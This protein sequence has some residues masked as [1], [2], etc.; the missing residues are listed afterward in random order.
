MCGQVG[1]IVEQQ[2][3]KCN[4]IT[5]HRLEKSKRKD[6]K[7]YPRCKV[8]EKKGNE[9]KYAKS[10]YY[11]CLLMQ[12]RGGCCEW[13]GWDEN[14]ALLQ[15]HHKRDKEFDISKAT[16][17]ELNFGK[18]KTETYKCDLICPHCHLGHHSSI[19]YYK[20]LKYSRFRKGTL[21]D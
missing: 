12:E 4:V 10:V 18:V 16:I 7:P 15:W 20:T 13:C 2:C 6:G 11:N 17:T 1:D 21:Y 19:D 9:V 5:K 8:C 3:K 14:P